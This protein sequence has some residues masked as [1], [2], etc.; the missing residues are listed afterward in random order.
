MILEKASGSADSVH[1]ESTHSS[2]GGCRRDFVQNL[3]RA[4]ARDDK[5]IIGCHQ[6]GVAGDRLGDH[7]LYPKTPPVGVVASNDVSN[8]HVVV[9]GL[10]GDGTEEQ[11]RHGHEGY[12]LWAS[13]DAAGQ[14][15]HQ[16]DDQRSVVLE[17]WN[18][19]QLIMVGLHLAHLRDDS[20]IGGSQSVFWIAGSHLSH[21]GDS[22]CRIP[23][24]HAGSSRQAH[25]FS[26]LSCRPLHRQ[27]FCRCAGHDVFTEIGCDRAG[28]DS[29]DIRLSGDTEEQ[30]RVGSLRHWKAGRSAQVERRLRFL[31]VAVL[32]QHRIVALTGDE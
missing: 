5:R 18:P 26:S 16:V 13:S 24:M 8:G 9:V 1:R 20:G 29:V 32:H 10:V 25:C 3:S 2:D 30:L 31:D 22:G 19:R 7:C 4:W 6:V 27:H 17:M 23:D 21:C 28:L 11:L 12:A 15:S 14:R